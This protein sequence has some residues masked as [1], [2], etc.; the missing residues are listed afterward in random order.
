M[1]VTCGCVV[2][3]VCHWGD[4]E[5]KVALDEDRGSP[6]HRPCLV[7]SGVG[8]E[9]W[10]AD[11]VEFRGSRVSGVLEDESVGLGLEAEGVVFNFVWVEGDTV[12]LLSYAPECRRLY[13]V[14]GLEKSLGGWGEVRRHCRCVVGLSVFCCC[15]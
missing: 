2:C 1:E 6:P 11:G 15:E 4:G 5:G 13:G 12:G 8:S 9:F 7:S 14:Y 3:V 10:G